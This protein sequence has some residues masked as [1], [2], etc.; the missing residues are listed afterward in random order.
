M[1]EKKCFLDRVEELIAKMLYH[2]EN[3]VPPYGDFPSF[4]EFF[5]NEDDRLR[6]IV[7]KFGMK[8]YKMPNDVQPDKSIRY[9]EA[10][11]YTPCGG[12][13]ADSVVGH[14]RNE[15]IVTLLKSEDFSAKLVESYER[16]V[17]CL[18]DL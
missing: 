12:Y 6:R 7:G 15:D 4:F 8:L 11:V 17:Y 18:G 3:N 1:E 10:T 9:L 13:K 16:L 5:D 14:G 2:L